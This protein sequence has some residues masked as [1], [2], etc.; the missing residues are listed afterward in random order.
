MIGWAILATVALLIIFITA[1]IALCWASND[2]ER[3]ENLL[4]FL[5]WKKETPPNGR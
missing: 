2:R 1:V 4:R 5:G 3:A